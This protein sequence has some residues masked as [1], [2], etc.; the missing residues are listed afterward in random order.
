MSLR[1]LWKEP[2]TY[3]HSLLTHGLSSGTVSA[4]VTQIIILKGRITV[5]KCGYLAFICGFLISANSPWTACLRGGWY[6]LDWE[7]RLL[8]PIFCLFDKQWPPVAIVIP[9]RQRRKSGMVVWRATK[10]AYGGWVVGSNKEQQ[11]GNLGIEDVL[12]LQK[13]CHKWEVPY[14]SQTFIYIHVFVLV[15]EEVLAKL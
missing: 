15:Y 4:D 7:S 9:S 10:S 8:Q 3:S 13:E 5:P 1:G 6:G 11:F 2:P 12:V 14:R